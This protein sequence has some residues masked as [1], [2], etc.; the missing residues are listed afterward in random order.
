MALETWKHVFD[1]EAEKLH[2]QPQE[3][4]RESKLEVGQG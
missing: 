1:Q 4:G 2:P 3:E